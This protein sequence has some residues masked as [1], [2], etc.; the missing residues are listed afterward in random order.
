MNNVTFFSTGLF[1]KGL[2]KQR[3][4]SYPKLRKSMFPT[5]TADHSVYMFKPVLVSLNI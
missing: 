4:L 5:K 3:V 1:K 2:K